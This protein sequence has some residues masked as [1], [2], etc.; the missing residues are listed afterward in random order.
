[1]DSGNALFKS[2]TLPKNDDQQLIKAEGLIDIYD[3]MAFDAVN[4]GPQDLAGGISFLK[5]SVRSPWIS[6]NFYDSSELPVFPQYI[7]KDFGSLKVAVVGVTTSPRKL[8]KGYIYKDWQDI[9]PGIIS[10][11]ENKAQFIVLLST[12]PREINTAIAER[13]SNIRVIVSSDRSNGNLQPRLINNALLTQTADQGKYLGCLTLSKPQKPQ[14]HNHI[15]LNIRGVQQQLQ[16]INYRLNRLQKIQAK[17]TSQDKLF[18]KLTTQ[19]EELLA[20]LKDLQKKQESGSARERS[21][22]TARFIAL[23]NRIE[24]DPQIQ[25][26]VEQVKD[27]VAAYN[28]K[29]QQ[30]TAIQQL[31]RR[32]NKN[33][34]G[35]TTCGQCHEPQMK[36]W[37]ATSHANAITT[38]KSKGE[39]DNSECLVCHVTQEPGLFEQVSQNSVFLLNLPKQ[40]Q[41]VGCES[42]HGAG[43]IHVANPEEKPMDTVISPQVCLN[44]HTPERDDDF[45]YGSKRSSIACPAI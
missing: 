35:Y 17:T 42:C 32:Y 8:T 16:P 41:A 30:E 18:R 21:K 28:K 25:S 10:E 1:M 44:C 15:E 34:T 33:L 19:K 22:Y 31:S 7:L 12:Y 14:W 24:D 39:A 45:N 2:T 36:F 20:K 4:I 23:G 43:R 29:R 37:L 40:L 26:M 5:D 38:L 6:A 27:K 11:L 13:Y 3:R 9:L